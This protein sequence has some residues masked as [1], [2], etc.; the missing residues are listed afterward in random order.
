[1]NKYQYLLE[2][3]Q[4]GTL[5]ILIKEFGFPTH[6]LNWMEIYQYHLEHPKLSQWQ[7]SLKYDVSKKTVWMIYRFMNQEL[8][9]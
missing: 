6:F 3:Q 1:M 9:H 4:A 8:T 5:K 7:L 2:L